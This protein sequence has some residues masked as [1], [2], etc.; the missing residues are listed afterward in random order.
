MELMRKESP[1]KKQQQRA[2]ADEDMEI[3]NRHNCAHNVPT[4]KCNHECEREGDNER[5]QM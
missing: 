4:C 2:D 3:E 1:Q 5:Q